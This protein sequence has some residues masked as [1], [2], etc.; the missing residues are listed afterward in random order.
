M[1]QTKTLSLCASHLMCLAFW[2]DAMVGFLVVE[3]VFDELLHLES[4]IT[5]SSI[6]FFREPWILDVFSPCFLWNSLMD[7]R[8]T[9]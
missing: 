5:V 3:D 2:T 8:V 4:T 7:F 6:Q 1:L 9:C